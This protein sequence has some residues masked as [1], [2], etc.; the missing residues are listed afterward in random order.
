MSDDTTEK[1][2]T[3]VL[4]PFKE[5]ADLVAKCAKSGIVSMDGRVYSSITLLESKASEIP[6]GVDPDIAT[7]LAKKGQ[8]SEH[9]GMGVMLAGS[10]G[11][12][13]VCTM[14]V[15]NMLDEE[16]KLSGNTVNGGKHDGI[17][18]LYP[19]ELASE[20]G[21]KPEKFQNPDII[22]GHKKTSGIETYGIGIYRFEK[23][24]SFLGFG[25][26]GTSGVLSFKAD[27]LSDD[28]AVGW[29]VPQNGETRC[30]V[31]TRPARWNGLAG[32]YNKFID[33]DVSRILDN[34]SNTGVQVHV[35]TQT[36]F[37]IYTKASGEN[38]NQVLTVVIEKA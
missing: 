18:T 16:I 6:E 9:G 26:Y 20:P 13:R 31:S 33:P 19:A 36:W 27:S 12:N 5:I 28:I 1:K 7:N 30:A 32:F 38:Y 37:G 34:S 21:K 23:D 24:L 3:P 2:P 22:P 11:S 35:S 15:L 4:T 25:V 8:L 14:V 17:Q 10:L 29:C